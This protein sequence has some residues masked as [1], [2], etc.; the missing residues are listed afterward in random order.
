MGSLARNSGASRDLGEGICLRAGVVAIVETGVWANEF[1]F[2]TGGSRS[3]LVVADCG[4]NS[5]GTDVRVAGRLERGGVTNKL[6]RIWE[7]PKGA[8]VVALRFDSGFVKSFGTVPALRELLVVLLKT[9]F[10]VDDELATAG[11]SDEALGRTG[12]LVAFGLLSPALPNSLTDFGA[13]SVNKR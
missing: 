10:A 6:A 7:D 13:L 3:L 2:V 11:G 8:A 12:S 5:S 4:D 9:G 1:G